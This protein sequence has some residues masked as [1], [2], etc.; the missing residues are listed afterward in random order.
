[1]EMGF[2]ALRRNEPALSGRYESLKIGCSSA[3]L[4]A[5]LLVAARQVLPVKA[6]T[7]FLETL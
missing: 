5:A 6:A 7:I 3:P 1:M 2:V 4:C